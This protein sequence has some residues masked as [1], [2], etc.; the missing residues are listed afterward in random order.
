[1]HITCTTESSLRKY[2]FLFR[3]AREHSAPVRLILVD[4]SFIKMSIALPVS[5]PYYRCLKVRSREPNRES[6]ILFYLIW[7]YLKLD[8]D[9]D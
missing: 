3:R 9:K 8:E 7:P 4:L 2:Y 5:F 1:M 6:R